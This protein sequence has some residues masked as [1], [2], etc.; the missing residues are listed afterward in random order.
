MH[1]VLTGLP[2]HRALIATIDRELERARRTGRQF[3]LLFLNLDH[4]K[5]I[6]G[7]AGHAAGDN[8][9]PNWGRRRRACDRYRR[10]LG[11]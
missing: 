4:F 7:T 2:N 9:L 6:D 3:A 8:A 1:D 10:P 11:W 5:S